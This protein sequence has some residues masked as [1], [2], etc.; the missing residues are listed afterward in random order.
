MTPETMLH[1]IVGPTLTFMSMSPSIAVPQS[2]EAAVLVLT[3]AG[4]ESAWKHRRQQ[5]GP[6]RGFWQFENMG[7]V[8]EV[9]QK[10]PRQLGTVCASYDIPYDQPV[11]FEA[12]CWNDT[13]ACAMA[14]LL[15]WQDPAPLPALGDRE[16]GWNYYV[17][18]WRPGAPH[19]DLWGGLYTQA[20]AALG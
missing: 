17:R 6:A 16:G 1:R 14:R 20:V 10:T 11:I 13:L 18:N 19:P 5:G 3:I 2:K 7:G 12:M 9:M 4:Q 15:L 8:A